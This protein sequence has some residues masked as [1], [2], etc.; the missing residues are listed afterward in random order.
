MKKNFLIFCIS[1]LVMMSGNLALACVSDNTNNYDN[2]DP[3]ELVSW[4][5]TCVDD[6]LMTGKMSSGSSNPTQGNG[7]SKN[8]SHAGN[9]NAYGMTD[10]YGWGNN[11]SYGNEFG[12]EFDRKNSG[13]ATAPGF[14]NPGSP[15][16]YCGGTTIDLSDI[17]A[18][19]SNWD[20][21]VGMYDID[22]N[23]QIIG[24]INIGGILYSFVLN[25]M[26]PDDVP[27][28]PLPGTLLLLG[29]AAG[30]FGIVKRRLG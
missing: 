16:W 11:S 9:G 20:L 27:Q 30:L 26:C 28:V 1:L 22:E 8:N 17:L 23:G 5:N 21:F 14:M 19:I 15:F 3:M 10:S 18:L 12:N 25:P 13:H 6:F 7:S 2:E 24:T 29:S 4:E